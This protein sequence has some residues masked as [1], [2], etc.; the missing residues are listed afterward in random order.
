MLL[1]TTRNAQYNSQQ[2]ATLAANAASIFADN[3]M[4]LLP[5]AKGSRKN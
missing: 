1:E 5:L 4:M 3:E 2:D